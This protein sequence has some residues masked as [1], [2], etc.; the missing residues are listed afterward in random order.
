VWIVRVPDRDQAASV[1]PSTT[2][3]ERAA[4]H[5]ARTHG[6]TRVV[7]HDRNCRL[8]TFAVEQG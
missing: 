3:A 4:R 1:H 2:H 8:R 5:L 7:V 6:A